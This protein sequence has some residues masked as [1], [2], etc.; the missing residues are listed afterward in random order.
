VSAF[1]AACE[2]GQIRPGT[3]KLKRPA[4]VQNKVTPTQLETNTEREAVP[5]S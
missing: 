4:P 3:V 2:E 1:V 5:V